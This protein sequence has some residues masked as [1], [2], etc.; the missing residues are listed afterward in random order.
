MQVDEIL[1][2][3]K[4]VPTGQ[5]LKI[6]T[7]SHTGQIV[8]ANAVFCEQRPEVNAVVIVAAV[9]KACPDCDGGS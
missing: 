9:I 2:V 6:V 4:T 8:L 3:L 5:D 1:E 7:F